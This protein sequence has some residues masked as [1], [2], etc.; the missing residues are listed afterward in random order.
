MSAK[1]K[2]N[3]PA[4]HARL[5]DVKSVRLGEVLMK[6]IDELRGENEGHSEF[7]RNTL[8]R[9]LLTHRE[10]TLADCELYLQMHGVTPEELI[11]RRTK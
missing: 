1:K 3:P 11:A 8:E 10:R 9:A 4:R 7:I 6:K 5:D 2:K